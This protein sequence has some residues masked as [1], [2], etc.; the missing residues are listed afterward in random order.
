M[1][2]FSGRVAWVTGGGRGIGRAA[3]LALADLGA[4]V[5]ISARTR[6]EI[7]EAADEVRERGGRAAPFACDVSDWQSVIET[8]GQVEALLGPID[9]LINNAGVLGQL[10]PL[11]ETSPREWARTIEINLIGAYHCA[12][13]ALPGMIGRGRGSIVNISSGAASFA[14]PNWSAYA[15]SKAGLDQLTR[16]LAVELKGTRVRVNSLHPGIVETAMAQRLRAAPP[17]QLPAWRRQFFEQVKAEGKVLSP[18]TAGRVIAWLAS[19]LAS[20]LNGEV[21]DARNDPSII[22]RAERALSR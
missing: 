5:A 7:D 12:R 14:A 1:S 3:T 18:E 9:A 11:Q 20:D 8:V 15:A 16:A 10:A 13:A 4:A 2:L 22:D 19:D 17:E 21:L 6:G